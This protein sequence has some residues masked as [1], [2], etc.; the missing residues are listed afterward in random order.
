MSHNIALIGAGKTGAHVTAL[1][2]D[3]ESLTI[4]GRSKP[5]T[6][7]ALKSHDVIICFLPPQAFLEYMP[8]LLQ[9]SVPV[10][11]GTTGITWP[12]DWDKQLQEQNTTW[13]HGKNFALG[14]N[15]M[16][17]LIEILSQAEDLYTNANYQIHEVHHTSK[18]DA[19]SGT[20]LAM[21][22][23]L[24]RPADITYERTDD[25]VGDHQI[26]LQTP[27]EEITLSHRALDRSIFA[28][29]AL[30]AARY[31]LNNDVP[32]GLVSFETISAQRL[33]HQLQQENV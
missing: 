29:G 21:Q 4:Y 19:P 17:S 11:T 16:K 30:W 2:H 27:F 12:T 31:V 33:K 22:S 24:N 7:D 20:A 13:V 28:H 3:S 8:M 5:A 25:V 18:V 26:H 1:I 14:M 32:K 15:I 10:V 23:W 9:A 6:L